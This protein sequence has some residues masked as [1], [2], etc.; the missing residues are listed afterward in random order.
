[1]AKLNATAASVGSTSVER[2]AVTSTSSAGLVASVTAV[3]LVALIGADARAGTEKLAA[4]EGLRFESGSA[5]LAASSQA[6]VI[7]LADV[8]KSRVATGGVKRVRIEGHTDATGEPQT[9]LALSEQRARAIAKV[10]ES[11][12]VASEL[13]EAIGY[14]ELRPIADNATARG[15]EQNRRVEI[16]LFSGDA[17]K[18]VS[19][20]HVSY[21]L[22]DVGTREPR[23]DDWKTAFIDQQLFEAWR[24]AARERSAADVSFNPSASKIHV[25]ENTVIVVFGRDAAVDAGTDRVSLEHGGL[26]AHLAGLAG[27]PIEV[28]SDASIAQV[29]SADVLVTVDSLGT[30]RVANHK[31]KGTRVRGARS[32]APPLELAEGFGSAVEVGKEPSPP[33]ALPKPPETIAASQPQVHVG[34]DGTAT[35]VATWSPVADATAYHLDWLKADG[36]L[37]DART[38]TADVTSYTAQQLVVGDYQLRVSVIDT[39]QFEG[40]PSP[41]LSLAVLPKLAAVAPQP[42]PPRQPVAVPAKTGV[43]LW[44]A[45]PP[46]AVA[47]GS[48]AG[49]GVLLLAPGI[50]GA[51]R[52]DEVGVAAALVGVVGLGALAALVVLTAPAQ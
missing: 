20:A 21:T 15:R 29:Q 18:G 50:T 3:V 8:V 22:N 30:S 48:A 35:L 23:N 40:A 2:C 44:W 4:A 43:P 32:V 34:D 36:T 13:I 19:V 11:N 25:R 38:V 51:N 28:R 14:G 27:D 24:V 7:S 31:G 26:S 9:N 52:N 41:P 12:G 6:V 49:A 37:L 42:P 45:I 1:M 5:A 39:A 46:A 47:V 17:A 10:L 33:H 16:S